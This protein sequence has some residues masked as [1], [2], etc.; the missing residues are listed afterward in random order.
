M[1][2]P[3]YQKNF[4]LIIHAP[5]LITQVLAF[6]TLL[7]KV[8]VLFYDLMTILVGC[9]EITCK[10]VIVRVDTVEHRYFGTLRGNEK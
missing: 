3:S 5:N 4:L 2:H 8:T 9:C 1:Y 7:I 10:M 6:C